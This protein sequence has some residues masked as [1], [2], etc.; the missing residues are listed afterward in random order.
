MAVRQGQGT[1]GCHPPRTGPQA[2][3]VRAGPSAVPKK[4]TRRGRGA[5]TPP[6]SHQGAPGVCGEPKPGNMSAASPGSRRASPSPVCARVHLPPAAPSAAPTPAPAPAARRP[7]EPTF[8]APAGPPHLHGNGK[9]RCRSGRAQA[10]RTPALVPARRAPRPA[11]GAG[12]LSLG[13]SG[14]LGFRDQRRSKGG[15][16]N[17]RCLL[18]LT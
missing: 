17:G 18:C 2:Q 9:T 16:W 1:R 11:G 7:T 6:R 12:R 15:C 8:R 3:A 4:P 13:P 10:A 14:M 5:L